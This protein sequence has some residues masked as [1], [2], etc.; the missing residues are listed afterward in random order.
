MSTTPSTYR[1]LSRDRREVIVPRSGNHI[2]AAQ[3]NLGYGIGFTAGLLSALLVEP[4][5]DAVKDTHVARGIEHGWVDSHHRVDTVKERMVNV[6][7]LTMDQ[8]LEQALDVA[9]QKNA[10]NEQ[11][12]SIGRMNHKQ[13]CAYLA[14]NKVGPAW[15]RETDET[16]IGREF[17]VASKSVHST[18]KPAPA[19]VKPAPA[20]SPAMTGQ[21]A[22]PVI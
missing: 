10:T 15:D 9:A 20:T 13:L 21:Y 12:E 1:L 11:M 18:A 17:T 4:V 22:V 3:Q 5:V 16:V 6:R 7:S 2:A 19:P 8:A 14:E